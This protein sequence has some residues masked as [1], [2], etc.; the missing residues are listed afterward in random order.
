[1][2]KKDYHA[3]GEQDAARED[4]GG[5]IT[6]FVGALVGANTGNY[7]P[8]SNPEEKELYDAGY[9]NTCKQR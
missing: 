7:R 8:P 4:N 6:T 2:S 9:R 3:K 1:M 5:F